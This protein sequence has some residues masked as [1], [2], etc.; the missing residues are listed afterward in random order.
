MI[1]RIGL[2]FIFLFFSIAA[3]KAQNP[4]LL[5]TSVAKNGDVT[6]TWDNSTALA[7]ASTANFDVYSSNAKNGPYSIIKTLPATELTFIHAGADASNKIVYYYIVM[8]C[9]MQLFPSNKLS[10]ILVTATRNADNADLAWNSPDPLGL[11]PYQYQVYREFPPNSGKWKSIKTTSNT[12]FSDPIVYCS[13]PNY[14]IETRD[15]N[16]AFSSNIMAGFEDITGPPV[17]E[18]T[19]ATVD[20]VTGKAQISWPVNPAGDTQGY[21]ILTYKSSTEITTLDTVKISTTTSYTDSKSNPSKA[22]YAYLVLPFDS[23]KRYTQAGHFVHHTILLKVPAD[24]CSNSAT[25]SWNKYQSWPGGVARYEIYENNVLLKSLD[26][27]QSSF[28][29]SSLSQSTRYIYYVKAVP[30]NTTIQPSLS[31]RD[32]ITTGNTVPPGFISVKSVTVAPG[33]EVI[34]TANVDNLADVNGYRLLRSTSPDGPFEKVLD[35]GKTS[36]GTLSIID[37]TALTQERSYFYKVQAINSC[38]AVALTSQNS[39]RTVFI[40]GSPEDE[41][42]NNLQWNPYGIND[43]NYTLYRSVDGHWQQTGLKTLAS[44]T[45]VYVDDVKDQVNSQG[46][47][48]YKITTHTTTN[49]SSMSNTFCLVQSPRLYVPNAFVPDGINK[50]FHPISVFDDTKSYDL[51]IYNRWGDKIFE[52]ND[53]FLGWD[54]RV[55]G[56]LVQQG[57]YVFVVSFTGMNGLP[58][59][60][61]GTVEMIR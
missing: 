59:K 37:N 23:C 15:P 32:T 52:T 36:N 45:L 46:N 13:Q 41:F 4:K 3:V 34:I 53:P 42:L 9:N 18:I 30:V 26:S 6:L 57:V 40:S 55:N 58:L 1:K 19:T 22:S 51:N 33:N 60:R 31:N 47:F 43:L 54:G 10:T 50:V 14:Y 7:C 11:I 48:C 29:R 8:N 25:L 12:S 44:G 17:T 2:Q 39:G 49:D 16:C 61:S 28:T 38:G 56:T 21:Y 20:P 5:C 35:V 24:L 27:T